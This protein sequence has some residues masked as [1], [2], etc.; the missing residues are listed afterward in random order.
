VA[1]CRFSA[2]ARTRHRED[3]AHPAPED[4]TEVARLKP[5]DNLGVFFPC[6]NNSYHGVTQIKSQG[7]ERDFLYINI[8]A[9]EMSLWK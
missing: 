5:R 4:V 2:Q 8:S 3:A 7:V 1:N 6:S 9:D